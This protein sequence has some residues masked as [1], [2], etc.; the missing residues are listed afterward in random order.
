[1]KT[2]KS[3]LQ[4]QTDRDALAFIKQKRLHDLRAWEV[5]Y[6]SD[7][8]DITAH[9]EFSGKLEVIA[10]TE[11]VNHKAIAEFIVA[12]INAHN[13]RPNLLEEAIRA[14]ELCVLGDKLTW[15]AEQAADIV[16]ARAKKFTV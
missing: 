12:I 2:K 8:S 11:G 14:L 4:N 3:A 5:S 7:H 16:I 9:V 15:E 1:M 10:R 13:R 6:Q